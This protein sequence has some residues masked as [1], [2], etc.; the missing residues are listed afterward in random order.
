M[1]RNCGEAG[2]PGI[3]NAMSEQDPG[4]SST[5]DA[6]VILGK[7]PVV[8]KPT[9]KAAT[10][11]TAAATVVSAEPAAPDEPA[12]V[13][14]F[15]PDEPAAPDEPV[16]S[17]EPFVQD[18][19]AAPDEPVVS[20]EPFVQD[21]TITPF[22]PEVWALGGWPLGAT[23]DQQKDIT[24]F[25]VF[26]PAA[27]R[28]V[29]EIYPEPLGTDASHRFDAV[30]AQNGTWRAQLIG[31]SPGAYYAYRCW[32]SN[33]EV[34]P[35]WRPGSVAGFISDRDEEGNHFNPNK[36]LLDPYAREVSHVPLS[37]AIKASGTDMGV[38]ATGG[39]DYRGKVR[40]AV[41]SA[42]YA[43]KG[44]VI[45]D[46]TPTGDYPVREPQDVMIYEAH[47]K[48]LTMH[49]SACRLGDLLAGE[50]LFGE[51]KNV[52]EP[53][54]G[55]Y[56][57]AAYLAPYLKALG[58]T[59]IELLPV[60]ETNSDQHGDTNGTTNFW[61]Y[62]T[63][64]FFAP[65]RDYSSDKSPGG[66]TR[67]F[68]QM[69][70]AFH[71]HGIEVYLDVVYNHTSE[72]GNWDND[73]DSAAFTSFGG[74]ATTIYYD[75][76]AD[77]WIVDDA[78]GSSNQTNFSHRPMCDLVMD[79]LSYWHKVMGVDGFR[80][81]LATV[82]GRFPAASDKE[83]WGGRRRFY[84]AHP[85]LRE[86]ADF[87]DQQDIE[88][89][90]EAWDLWGY[91]V[92]NFPS[93]WGEWNGR[94]RDTM[95]HYLKGDGNTRAFMDL[96]N[97]DWL[98]FNDNAGPQ[99]SINF[100]TAHDGFTMFDLVSFNDKDNQQPFP[101]GPSDGGT[102]ANVSWDSG[103]DQALRRARWRNNWLIP[104]MSRGVPMVVS[105]DE[106][107]R[108]QNGNNNPW[109]LNTIGMWNN[110]AMLASNTPTQLPVDPDDP[111]AYSYFDVVGTCDADPD[112]NPLFRF[113]QYVTR[114]RALDP[115]LRQKA[116]GDGKLDSDNVSYLYYRPDLEGPPGPT[117]RQVTVLINGTG[118]GGT[119]YL[120]MV[121]MYTHPADFRIPDVSE[122]QRPAPT[123]KWHRIIDTASWA[124][125]YTNSWAPADGEVIV[126]KY[127]V[128][129]WSIAVLAAASRESPLFNDGRFC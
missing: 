73:V 7:P 87:A 46:Q 94:F 105:G 12:A 29:L 40:R 81:D 97:G 91:E 74:F 67:E 123:L 15:V 128:E 22:A 52:P 8:D 75:L 59:S 53:L 104:M 60:H 116:W 57:G 34:D 115:T 33:W 10:A 80:F 88:V 83:D 49:P 11:E 41:D 108:T 71:E 44:V 84:K 64:G 38:F 35:D 63:I 96:L 92:G 68:K 31:V 32:G 43:P 78:T 85:L 36:V 112:V 21:D 58:F 72:G 51:V 17:D 19:P 98:H 110:W 125:E 117:D 120:M 77:G 106:Y 9:V 50:K 90:A 121:N 70:S 54:R 65:N 100:L 111:D 48:N 28:V 55:T 25:A 113:A 26:A 69:V 14:P 109:S 24:S 23:H 99:K 129:P 27:T 127:T 37:P 102:D 95:R 122:L 2:R 42:R 56:A 20:D 118:I 30:K 5:P 89:I 119:D 13:E 47:I 93:G 82:L 103:G 4:E 79:S 61:G 62:Q 107:G 66:P 86:V 6:K 114:L 45:H 76:T 126:D 124:E 101:F 18:E 1:S 16:V 3:L 39:G